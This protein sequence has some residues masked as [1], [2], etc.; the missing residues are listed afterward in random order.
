MDHEFENTLAHYG[1]KGMRWGIRKKRD[2]APRA[3]RSEDSVVAREL[4]VKAKTSS[5]GSLSNDELRKVNERMNLEQQYARLVGPEPQS[6]IKTGLLFAASLLVDG[7]NQVA[8][9]QLVTDVAEAGRVRK[10]GEPLLPGTQKAL[11]T[12]D[13]VL[14]GAKLINMAAP[15]KK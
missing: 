3:P 12:T 1:I 5:V 15:K 8:V 2:D 11:Q 7:G 4:F 9:K 13:K 6:K 14:L 10:E